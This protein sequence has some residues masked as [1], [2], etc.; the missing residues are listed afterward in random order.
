M[1]SKVFSLLAKTGAEILG[2]VILTL[3]IFG[4]FYTGFLNTGLMRIIGPLMVLTCGI[5]AYVGVMYIVSKP[6]EKNKSTRR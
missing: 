2:A 5:G 3:T 6:G 1:L 4:M